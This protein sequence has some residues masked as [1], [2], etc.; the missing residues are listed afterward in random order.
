MSGGRRVAPVADGDGRPR[1]GGAVRPVV[2][3]V[4]RGRP[5]REAPGV[6]RTGVH[7]TGRL[8]RRTGQAVG[9]ADG[10]GTRGGARGR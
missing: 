1:A 6:H 10:G 3:D 9:G 5:A 4:V 2:A 7:R 8:R